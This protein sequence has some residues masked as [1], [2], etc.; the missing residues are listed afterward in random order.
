M[1]VN[2]L[3]VPF[4]LPL[5]KQLGHELFSVLTFLPSCLDLVTC[6]KNTLMHIYVICMSIC[7][8]VCNIQF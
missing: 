4:L 5:L 7:V 8:T 2:N 1:P 6:Y 3:M